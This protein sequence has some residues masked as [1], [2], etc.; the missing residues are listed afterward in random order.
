MWLAT[1]A[2]AAA[3]PDVLKA[4]GLPA[5]A[6]IDFS[7]GWKERSRKG[8][9]FPHIGRQSREWFQTNPRAINVSL[10]TE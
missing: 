5:I 2:H 10:L 3:P 7:G 8:A 9:A 1:L 4:C 6:L